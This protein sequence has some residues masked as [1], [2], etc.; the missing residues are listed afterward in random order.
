MGGIQ[1]MIKWK[2]HIAPFSVQGWDGT[3][4]LTQLK[5]GAGS[6]AYYV[7]SFNQMLITHY[8]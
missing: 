5:D 7:Q 4:E 3:L 1:T 8:I 6:L 2:V